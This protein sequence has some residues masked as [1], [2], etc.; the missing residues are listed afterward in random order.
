MDTKPKPDI[1]DVFA[2]INEAP[3]TKLF[4]EQVPEMIAELA[5]QMICNTDL[6]VRTRLRTRIKAVLD[7]ICVDT[8][9]PPGDVS[10]KTPGLLDE[11]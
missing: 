1:A 8:T 11:I 6:S 2:K 10:K 7:I 5:K 3:S 9:H 4:L